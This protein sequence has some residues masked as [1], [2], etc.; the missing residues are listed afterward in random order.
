MRVRQPPPVVPGA[1]LA[2][3]MADGAQRLATW[4]LLLVGS[5]SLLLI[6]WLLWQRAQADLRSVGV[7]SRIHLIAR[8]DGTT[9]ALADLAQRSLVRNA[10]VDAEGRAAYLAPM[11][12]EHRRGTRGLVSLRLLDHAGQVLSE[13]HAQPAS[14]GE[15]PPSVATLALSVMAS[16]QPA[17]ALQHVGDRWHLV[18]AF[19]VLFATTG[20]VEGALLG[21]IDL[22]AVFAA[23]LADFAADQ[24]AADRSQ[25]RMDLRAA[26][27]LV[28]ESAPATGAALSVT[29]PLLL[30]LDQRAQLPGVHGPGLSLSVYTPW[31]RALAPA[32]WVAVLY[33]VMSALTV[34]AVRRRT[35]GL[36]ERAVRPLQALRDAARSVTEDGLDDVPSLP[37][38]ELQQGGVEVQSLAF[39]FEAMLH[40]LQR[41]QAELERTVSERTAEL[42]L[43]KQRLDG[44]LASL[45]DGVYSL[46][47]DRQQLLYASPP[48]RS[49]LGLG[50][51]DVP[52]VQATMQRV[53]GEAHD[54]RIMAAVKTALALG[55]ASLRHEVHDGQG[56]SRWVEDRMT[57]VRDA[58]G[59]PLRLDGI[60]SDV[61][62]TV[63]AQAERQRA[64]D[65]MLLRDSALASTGNGVLILALGQGGA[66]QVV[67]ANPALARITGATVDALQAADAALLQSHVVGPEM[68]QALRR[69]VTEQVDVRI[70]S[71]VRQTDGNLIWCELAISPMIDRLSRPG[72]VRANGPWVSHVVVVV[73]DVTERRRQKELH[74]Q[75]VQSINEVI[76]QTDTEGH[77]TFLNPAWTRITG[78]EVDS[79]LDTP[80]L[81]YVHPEDR[82]RTLAVFEPMMLGECS[83][84]E[85]EARW[86]TQ[87]GR[88]RWLSMHAQG[89]VDDDGRPN[90]FTGTLT[91]ITARREAEA[92]LRLR[93]RAVDA[94][95][96]GILLTDA[97]QP[98]MPVVFVNDGFSRITGYSRAESLGRNCSFLQGHDR[99]Q[100]GLAE[101]RDAILRRQ[102]CRVLLRNY[103]KDGTPF[104]NDLSVAPVYDE[105]TGEVTH[106]VGVISDVSGRLQAERLLHD[107]FARLDTIL[108]LSP[109]GFVSFDAAQ[110]VAS[111]N[112]AFE[113]ITGM[114]VDEIVG[115][116]LDAFEERLNQRVAQRNPPGMAPWLADFADSTT[117][118]DELGHARP[119]TEVLVLKGLP[120]RVL[121]CSHS[122]CDAPDV[123]G[124]M[125]LRDITEETEVDRMKSEFLSTAA[126]ELRTPMASI[127]GF[128]DLLLMRNFDEA[129]TRD[130]L[131]TI[132]RQSIW[133]TDMINELLDLARIEARKGKDFDLELADLRELA[134]GGVASLMV[135]GD[136]REVRLQLSEAPAPVRVDR[137]KFQHALTNVLSNAYKYSP[138]G[139][140]ITLSVLQAQRKGQA[141]WGVAVRDQGLGMSPEHAC[142]AF[143]RFFRAD[144]SG[145]IPGTGL[146][147]ALVKEIIELHG[148]QV[149]LETALGQGTCLT[150]WLPQWAG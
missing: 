29:W 35:A 27:Q 147:L 122:D 83:T 70:T 119:W 59:E 101:L 139:G 80:F 39:S 4:G 138:Q 85:H 28:A 24:D 61:S 42:S 115:L 114:A 64:A 53:L 18:V 34:A 130:V 94:S 141:M 86:L 123:S 107:Q 133:L 111:A 41:A 93:T 26:G 125:Y 11:L 109:D 104:D 112:P 124:V 148:G 54:R 88:L 8:L 92:D 67:Y 121:V 146:G 20:S 77:W 126:H 19:P 76:F 56:S 84:C 128:S 13:G 116:S 22:P 71:R 55:T 60:L 102:S 136:A 36:A 144:S 75:V 6:I 2:R 37:S 62:A 47:V 135:P 131:Q 145:S 79:S 68:A 98:G 106:F 105:L 57:L 118:L 5:L 143:E 73:D 87:D 14:R 58:R 1:G 43:A 21:E 103:R 137:A 38:H 7:A 82:Q 89:M 90:G 95:T 25:L 149:E 81:G 108:T 72:Q 32:L 23:E 74:R 45:S 134:R 110:R 49:L 31:L 132:N 96:N 10:L 51:D 150:L 52:M 15:L 17:Q 66:G 30:D 69:C 91:D 33:A 44:T 129:R 120:H 117:H 78:F 127:R 65:G 40:R 12:D 140:E 50:A 99:E 63:R 142:R 46:S 100:S 3:L 16:A 97:R 113:R 9:T 48:V